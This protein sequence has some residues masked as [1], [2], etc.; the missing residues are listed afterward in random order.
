VIDEDVMQRFGVDT[1]QVG[2][3]FD[4]DES[5]WGDWILPDGTPCKWLRCA[6]PQWRDGEW[7]LL[8]NT[9]KVVAHMPKGVLNFEPENYPFAE[10]DSLDTG[11]IRC[12]ISEFQFTGIPS[13]YTAL[14]EAPDG[15][16]RFG[17]RLRTVYE[18]SDRAIILP[19]GGHLLEMGQW[20]YRA[21]N[22]YMMMAAQPKRTHDFLDHVVEIH[23]AELDKL[24]KFSGPFVDVIALSDDLGGQTSLLVSPVMFR[25]FFKE[26]LRIIWDHIRRLS[27][28][29][30]M[31]HSCGAVRELIP[32][33]IDI[34]LDILN[35]IQIDCPGMDAK[36]LKAEF[37]QDLVLWGGGCDTHRVL[38]RGSPEDVHTHVKSQISI[39]RP[40]G[41]FVFQQV[42]NILADVP[43]QN[44]V[45]MYEA[46]LEFG[47]ST[48]F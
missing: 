4:Q 39:L 6:L 13:A 44:I 22:F 18:Q 47:T 29:K 19:Y 36:G 30:I 15:P 42:H 31:L 7:V 20:L 45:S 34:G 10:K 40:G 43:P 25:E 26:R 5:C 41:G 1:F 2:R 9:G 24:L 37:G 33:F 48:S 23:C 11:D 35:P 27:N 28:A 14:L 38:P 46:V 16:A 32:D 17:E 12:A 3:A 8:S 21:D